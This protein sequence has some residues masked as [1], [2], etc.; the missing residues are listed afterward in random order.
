[1]FDVSNDIAIKQH[2]P[3]GVKE[4][5]VSFPT[6]EQWIARAAKSKMTSR[7]IGNGKSTSEVANAE[8]VNSELFDQIFR[9]GAE[10][11]EYEKSEV[12]GRLSRAEVIESSSSPSGYEV[13]LKVPGGD[14]LH[15]LKMPSARQVAEYRRYAVRV[16]EGR[17]GA[18]EISINLRASMELYDALKVSVTGY[19]AA[20]PAIHK[21]AVISEVL[22]MLD[23]LNDDCDVEGF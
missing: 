11:D 14:T 12:I 23:S 21:S 13:K 1:M 22:A 16:V 20:I 18:S 2:T 17:R 5:T 3:D 6:D 19:A 8:K 9:G 15:S 4:V 7:S 10:L